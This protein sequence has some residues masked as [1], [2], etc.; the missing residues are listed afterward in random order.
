MPF[1]D[2]I[3]AVQESAEEKIREIRERARIE[4]DE[5]LDEARSKEERIKQGGLDT[6]KHSLD[7]DKVRQ[8]AALREAAKMQLAK[9]KEELY[10]RS[11]EAAEQKLD[12]LRQESSYAVVFRRL[13]EEALEEK[14]EGEGIVVHID[15]RDELVCKHVLEELNV[16]LQVVPD[17][18]SSGGVTIASADQTSSILNNLE[19][20]LRMAKE[21]LR[22]EVFSILFGA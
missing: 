5:I 17:L 3:K 7:I 20:R 8:V 11:F 10:Q 12:T 14:Q 9:K 16:H 13:L 19:S 1:E 4:A 6:A 2:L 22:A 21:Q 15:P 18:N